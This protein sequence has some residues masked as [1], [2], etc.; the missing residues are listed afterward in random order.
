MLGSHNAASKLRQFLSRQ[1]SWRNQAI[2]LTMRSMS[3][4]AILRQL[5]M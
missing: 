4:K 5:R 3:E 1:D 2:A